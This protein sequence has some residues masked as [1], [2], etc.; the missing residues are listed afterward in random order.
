MDREETCIVT[1]QKEINARFGSKIDDLTSQVMHLQDSILTVQTFNEQ[2]AVEF[3]EE[4]KQTREAIAGLVTALKDSD[5]KQDARHEQ[6]FYVQQQ[7]LEANL[8]MLAIFQS[9]KK[10]NEDEFR[11]I[12]DKIVITSFFHK[13]LLGLGVMALTLLVGFFSSMLLPSFD[14]AF[15]RSFELFAEALRKLLML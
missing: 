4:R 3:K 8:Q 11:Q 13:G 5:A 9:H 15:H 12:G 2:L 14:S 7:N 1:N 10:S 6:T